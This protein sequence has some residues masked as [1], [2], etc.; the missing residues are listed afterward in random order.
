[1]IGNRHHRRKAARERVEAMIVRHAPAHLV[2]FILLTAIALAVQ[3]LVVQTHIHIPQAAGRSA[4][5]SIMTVAQNLIAGAAAEAAD[6]RTNLARDKYPINE[7]PSN[8][9]LCQEVAHSGQF[10]QSAASL[11]H[12]P[13]WFSVH[14]VP[15]SEA[16]PSFLAIS[17]SWQGRAPPR[18]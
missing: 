17:H 10:L 12:I 15:V 2:L 13:F 8:C 4:S 18:D 7:D 5:V 6:P 3:I 11:A 1:M 16:L 14:F 9:P